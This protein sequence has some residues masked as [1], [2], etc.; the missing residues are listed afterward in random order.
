MSKATKNQ[1]ES[2]AATVGTP[3][4]ER[5]GAKSRFLHPYLQLLIS[6]ILTAVSQ[7]WVERSIAEVLVFRSDCW[8]GR[9]TEAI[10]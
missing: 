2:N 8:E 10:Q 6:I 4:D 1:T 5:G 9:M 3:D 7:I